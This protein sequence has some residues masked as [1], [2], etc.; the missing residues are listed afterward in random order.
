LAG[1]Q[2][3]YDRKNFFSQEP[4]SGSRAWQLRHS[5]SYLAALW[6]DFADLPREKDRSNRPG[7]SGLIK[8]ASA[9]LW[10]ATVGS[11]GWAGGT[12][13]DAGGE[14]SAMPN[15]GNGRLLPAVVSFSIFV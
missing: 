5:R 15:D 14:I 11:V 10:L 8:P 1:Q 12:I 2:S 7:G 6:I 9:H 3:S 4:T 13:W